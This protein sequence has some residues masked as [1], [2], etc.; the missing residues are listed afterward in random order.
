MKI[1]SFVGGHDINIY[2]DCVYNQSTRRY[3]GG[4][5]IAV[6]QYSGKMLSAKLS[7]TC[8]EPIDIDGVEI[9]VKTE[10]IFVDVDEIPPES[11]CDYAVVSAMYISACKSLGKDT[12]RLLTI[13][14]VVADENNNII[15]C[16][17]LNRN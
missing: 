3:Y 4:K 8:D 2:T 5:L 13:G 11:E 16:M 17:N 6:I 9:P 12:S 10:M 7:Q 14:D 15:G 1:K